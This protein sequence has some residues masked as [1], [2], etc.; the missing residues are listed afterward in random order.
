MRTSFIAAIVSL[1][2]ASGAVDAGIPG[3]PGMNV[4]V[5]LHGLNP[6]AAEQQ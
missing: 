5:G 4:E 3:F 2:V 1:L 6:R